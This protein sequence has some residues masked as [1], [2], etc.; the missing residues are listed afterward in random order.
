MKLLEGKTAIITGASSGNSGIG[1]TGYDAPANSL[2]ASGNVGPKYWIKLYNKDEKGQGGTFAGL[3][4][5][6]RI[7]L[8]LKGL[9]ENKML[10]IN[11]FKL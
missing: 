3:R 1:C 4:Y 8:R 5:F 7:I 10:D 9:Y 11:K 6:N 2:A